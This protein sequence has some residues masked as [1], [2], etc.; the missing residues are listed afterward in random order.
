MAEEVFAGGK[1]QVKRELQNLV[2]TPK[3][4]NIMA[5]LILRLF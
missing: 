4:H 2:V 1:L 5:N 3:Y